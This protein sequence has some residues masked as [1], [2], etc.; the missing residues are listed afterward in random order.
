[1]KIRTNFVSNSSS[2]SF[3][4]KVENYVTVFDLAQEMVRC[5]EWGERDDKLIEQIDRDGLVLDPNTPISFSSCNYDTYIV[6]MESVYVVQTSNNHDWEQLIPCRHDFPLV[7]QSVDD[8]DGYDNEY[9][10]Y[11][12]KDLA[13]FW[14]PEVRVQGKP[15]INWAHEKHP[16]EKHKYCNAVETSDGRIVCKYCEMEKLALAASNPFLKWMSG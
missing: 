1:M 2:S 8:Y 5:R 9:Y 15:S 11:Y 13:V 14:F 12:L 10:E 4:V 7:P 16:C 6:R 3:T